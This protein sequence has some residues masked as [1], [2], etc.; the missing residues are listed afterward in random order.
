M[1]ISAQSIRAIIAA[2]FL[3]AHPRAGAYCSENPE[4]YPVRHSHEKLV[5]FRPHEKFTEQH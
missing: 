4:P 2:G 5:P 3:S 1:R